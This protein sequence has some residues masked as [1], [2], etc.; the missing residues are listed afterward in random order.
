MNHEDWVKEVRPALGPGI[1]GRV[2]AALETPDEKVEYCLPATR[3]TMPM[4]HRQIKVIWKTTRA[5]TDDKNNVKNKDKFIF[6][7]IPIVW[8]LGR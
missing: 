2:H 1:S 5:S 7:S 8:R 3:A 6:I 4:Y